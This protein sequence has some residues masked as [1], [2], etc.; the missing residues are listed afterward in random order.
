M[1][2]ATVTAI[3]DGTGSMGQLLNAHH[4]VDMLN[5]TQECKV[6]KASLQTTKPIYEAPRWLA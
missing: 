6:M 2:L 1:A 3:I 5:V 4:T